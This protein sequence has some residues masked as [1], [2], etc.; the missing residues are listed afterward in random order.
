[1]NKNSNVPGLRSFFA[2]TGLITIGI[3]LTLLLSACGS[4]AAPR[5]RG[6][7]PGQFATARAA[8]LAAQP[9]ATAAPT[10]TSTP[11][12]APTSAPT[13]TP[14]GAIPM[15]GGFLSSFL[16]CN[17]ATFAS[18]VNVPDGTVLTPGQKF[19]KTWKVDNVG[20]CSWTSQYSLKW[21]GGNRMGGSNIALPQNVPSNGSADLSVALTAPSREGTYV[22]FWKLADQ[23][24][25]VFGE[26]LELQI[27]VEAPA[28]SPSPAAT[29][30]PF[31]TPTTPTPI[32]SLTPG[33]QSMPN[34]NGSGSGGG[35]G[36]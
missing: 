1:M 34:G 14:T 21:I 12:S 36:Y 5:R 7:V 15:T 10:D 9:T 16:T 27:V 30:N 29:S 19:T 24:G 25:H 20:S 31:A 32:P 6:G 23:Y 3:L 28:A 33:P 13:A 17:S 26:M 22:G 18:D 2:R 4:A 11:T 8:T 35:N